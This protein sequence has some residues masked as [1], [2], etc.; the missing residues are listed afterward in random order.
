MRRLLLAL[1]ASALL[2]AGAPR[3]VVSQTVGTDELL[4]A[5]A[6]PAQIAALSHLSRD[7]EYCAV[8]AEALRYPQLVQGDAETILRF[9]PDL[10]LVSSYTRPEMLA[11]LQRSGAR[12]LRFDRF[13]T[14]EEVYAN[15]R[16]LGD[17]LGARAKAEAVVKA[18][19]ERVEALAARLR[20]VT[21]VRVLV[22]SVYGFT[23]GKD[24]T[25]QDLCDHAG[26]LNVAAE[27]GLSGHAPTPSEAVLA[28]KV[29]ALVLS[30]EDSFERIRV[31]APY[32]Y[33]AVTKARRF[34]TIP[35]T[36]LSSV[37]HHRIGG[38]EALAR[39][40]HPERFK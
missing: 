15:L 26:A 4:L 35:G 1:F 37:S 18:C 30:R 27:A 34:V 40:L 29:D 6:D 31:L 23:A 13:N 2:F 22:P 3:R 33:M 39:A 19:R 38:Y 16:T 7:P 11:Q 14:L 10:V 36:Y 28:W 24:T 12:V 8:A 32:K 20:G 21:P 5:L 9:K 25:F 17:A